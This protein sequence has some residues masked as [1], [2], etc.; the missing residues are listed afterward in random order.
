MSRAVLTLLL[1]LTGHASPDAT[2]DAPAALIAEHP[3]LDAA[4]LL[5]AWRGSRVAAGPA[6]SAPLEV[7]FSPGLKPGTVFGYFTFDEAPPGLRLRR[8]GRVIADRVNFV[9]A[10]GRRISLKLDE[11]GRRLLGTVTERDRESPVEL[12]RLRTR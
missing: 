1:A 10:D 5:G 6:T 4:A 9:L 7:A 8:L 3:R 12:L 2:Q 11:G